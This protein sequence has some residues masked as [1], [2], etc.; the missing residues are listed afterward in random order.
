MKCGCKDPRYMHEVRSTD[1]LVA[2]LR[3]HDAFEALCNP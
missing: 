2:C 1:S 3:S